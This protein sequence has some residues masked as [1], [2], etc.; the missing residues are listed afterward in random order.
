[1]FHR[2]WQ[3]VASTRVRR[4]AL[5]RDP[6][7][8]DRGLGDEVDVIVAWKPS[9]RWKVEINL[10]IFLPGDAFVMQQRENAVIGGGELKLNF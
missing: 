7:G 1:V 4:W 9:R 10:G 8:I 6:D 3:N 2:Y 5:D